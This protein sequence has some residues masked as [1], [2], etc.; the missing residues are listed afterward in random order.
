MRPATIW[1]CLFSQEL[2]FCGRCLSLVDGAVRKPSTCNSPGAHSSIWPEMALPSSA[3]DPGW[4]LECPDVAHSLSSGP[5]KSL[6]IRSRIPLEPIIPLWITQV[7]C[8]SV[9]VN[10]QCEESKGMYSAGVVA[11]ATMRGAD[12][13]AIGVFERSP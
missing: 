7:S 12:E 11:F 13:L 8:T 2:G 5:F 3:Q 10:K 4:L 9:I 6:G 1:S